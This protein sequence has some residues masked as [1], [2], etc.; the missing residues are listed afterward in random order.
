MAQGSPFNGFFN[1]YDGLTAGLQ[2]M[3]VKIDDETRTVVC[4]L[5]QPDIME[6]L[7]LMHQW[8]ICLLYTSRCV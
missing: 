6:N 4:T 3:G 2:P 8:Y 5:E 1:E 7:K